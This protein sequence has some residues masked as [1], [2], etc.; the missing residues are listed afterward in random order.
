LGRR[1]AGHRRR[2]FLYHRIAAPPQDP[3]GLAI[4]KEWFQDQLDILSSKFR[5]VTLDE[6]LKERS[7]YASRFAAITFDDG[8]ADNLTTASPILRGAGI[9]A[10]FFICTGALGDRRG[11]WWDRLAR[12]V[13]TGPPAA[14]AA[15]AVR[16]LGSGVDL[17]DPDW[18]RV[19]TLRMAAELRPMRPSDR[20]RTL[21][22][23]EK[24]L[25]GPGGGF[26]TECPVID[27]SGVRELASLPLTEVAAHTQNHAMLSMLS[28]EEQFEEISCSVQ[29]IRRIAPGSRV[30]FLAYPYGGEQD[31][32]SAS[33]IAARDAG[34]EAAFANHGGRIDTS[35]EQFQ[36]PRYYV[37]PLSADG[38]RKWLQPLL[39]A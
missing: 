10:T 39:D 21:V 3:F 30:R 15:A 7:R 8:Y 6:I 23:L 16:T 14:V 5:I 32:D 33:A 28:R 36:V 24:I 38:F 9:P 18:R 22:D 4:C 27:A 2:I 29:A 19:A 11:F 13:A 20:D 35:R 1:P 34:L 26:S 37:P 12:A 31:Y 25:L 17:T